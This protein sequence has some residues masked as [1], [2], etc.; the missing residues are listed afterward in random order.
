M[1]QHVES[2]HA[3]LDIWRLKEAVGLVA[4][5]FS[6]GVGVIQ[7][8]QRISEHVRLMYCINSFWLG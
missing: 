4:V 8:G 6:K 5:A 1:A 2:S 3:I 7:D